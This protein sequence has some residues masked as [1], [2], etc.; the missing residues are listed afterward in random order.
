M[1]LVFFTPATLL[2]CEAA[3]P[4]S[5]VSNMTVHGDCTCGCG[6]RTRRQLNGVF[7][8][9]APRRSCAS[10]KG[11]AKRI[12]TDEVILTQI[13]PKRRLSSKTSPSRLSVDDA[14]AFTTKLQRKLRQAGAALQQ[15]TAERDAAQAA[16]QQVTAERN[17]AQ[18]ALTHMRK[19]VRDLEDRVDWQAAALASGGVVASV[20]KRPAKA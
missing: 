8:C 1:I 2:N 12:K 20:L 13:L 6:H 17:A 11:A 7:L 9:S 19:R 3:H 14:L 18:A 16:L 10:L 5:L 15:V 4:Y